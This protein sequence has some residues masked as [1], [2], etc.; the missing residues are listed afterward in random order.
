MKTCTDCKKSK[1]ESEFSINRQKKDG[2]NYRCKACQRAYFKTYY[3][4]NKKE[5]IQRVQQRKDN[6]Q[7]L[8][9][10]FVD[11]IKLSNGCAYCGYKDHQAALQFH[12]IDSKTKD[13][14]IANAINRNW[15]LDRLKQEI[16]KCI[17]LCA[18]CHF[19]LHYEERNK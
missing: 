17:V 9:Q 5:Q 15:G 12:H 16:K 7:A 2:L 4:K 11:D 13:D 8:L 18:N 10:K 14:T 19:I 6:N 1:D 3:K